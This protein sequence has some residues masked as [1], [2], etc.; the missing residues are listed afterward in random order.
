[1]ALLIALLAAVGTGWIVAEFRRI[2]AEETVAMLQAE[3]IDQKRAHEFLW[4]R[5]GALQQ[6][7]DAVEA[8]CLAWE[9][10]ARRLNV[11]VARA[12]EKFRQAT[13]RL[14]EVRR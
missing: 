2:A 7:A 4:D 11:E 9:A 8:N 13:Q 3:L 12:Q 6:H 10:K 14:G 1:M 5:H